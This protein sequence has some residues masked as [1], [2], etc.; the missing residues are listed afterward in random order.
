ML[1]FNWKEIGDRIFM[2]INVVSSL[3]CIKSSPWSLHLDVNLKEIWPWINHCCDYNVNYQPLVPIFSA[4]LSSLSSCQPPPVNFDGNQELSK[5]RH[6]RRHGDCQPSDLDLSPISLLSK[7]QTQL[8]LICLIQVGGICSNEHQRF[9]LFCVSFRS[10][11]ARLIYQPPHQHRHLIQ[12]DPGIL[13][14]AF[15]CALVSG[16]DNEVWE[17]IHKDFSSEYEV[18]AGQGLLIH[19]HF[20]TASLS[21]TQSP[22]GRHTLEAAWTISIHRQVL[23]WVEKW[24][25]P[26]SVSYK[27]K[28]RKQCKS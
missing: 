26:G 23:H 1:S 5:T 11:K 4:S 15:G 25:L 20:F 9:D 14:S 16:Y 6:N 27:I 24:K 22:C 18:V 28:Y 8:T 17:L 13:W 3:G 7:P 10:F 21:F 2:S 12:I 19:K